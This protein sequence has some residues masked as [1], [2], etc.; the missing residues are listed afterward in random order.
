[1]G[2]SLAA[3]VSIVAAA[4][5]E[6]AACSAGK[7]HWRPPE[8][9]ARK[10]LIYIIDNFATKEECQQV[11]AGSHGRMESARVWSGSMARQAM[12]SS[13]RSGLTTTLNKPENWT[14][15]TR[16]IIERMDAATMMPHSVGQYL[17]VTQYDVGD[18][19]ELHRDSSIEAARTL[20]A[21][22]F[23]E[24]PSKELLLKELLLFRCVLA[25]HRILFV[26]FFAGAPRTDAKEIMALGELPRLQDV[27]KAGL[28]IRPAQGRLVVF[29]SHDLMGRLIL[30][31]SLHGSCPVKQGIK[32]LAQR[33]Y[34]W[35]DVHSSNM[36]GDVQAFCFWFQGLD[37]PGGPG[38]ILAS[39]TKVKG[40]RVLHDIMAGSWRP[41]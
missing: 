21:I 35:H 27:C 19:Y 12:N 15:A 2:S 29:R 26:G 8:L 31:H 4:D 13:V 5:S 38:T 14:A 16:E 9:L 41:I 40:R 23:L 28:R 11:F 32:R 20:T 25:N 1:M 34:Q 36:L 6:D 10:P 37:F 18:S 33:W 7:Q 24:E 17:Q 30:P 3:L 22:L 39:E